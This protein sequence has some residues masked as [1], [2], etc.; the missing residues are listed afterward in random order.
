MI[1]GA[2]GG[3]GG[4]LGTRPW[5]SVVCLWRRLLAS[6]HCSSRPSVGPNV[7]WLCQR[8]PPDDLS[9]LT[10]PG[11]GR[12]GDGLLRVPLTRGILMHTPSPCGG[13]LTPAPACVRWCVHLR[14]NFPDRGFQQQG[15]GA[16]RSQSTPH[17]RVLVCI[18]GNVRQFQ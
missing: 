17:M 18:C 9:C 11:V 16:S 4:G 8:S 5:D 14:D 7:F 15:G 10:T 6:R 12:P 13:L 3:R 2:R 1:E